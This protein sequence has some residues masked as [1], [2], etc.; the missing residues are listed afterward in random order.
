M[1]SLKTVEL[2]FLLK[3]LG[4]E[5][6]RGKIID[7][8][9]NSATSTAERDRICKDLSAKGLVEYDA[10]VGSFSLAPPG[11]TLLTLDT[12]SLPVT[13]D[14]LKVLKAFKNKGGSMTP[15]K[16]LG[17]PAD[18]RQDLI[19][20]LSDRGMLKITKEAIKEVWLSAQGKQF[21]LYEFEPSGS[22]AA[23]SAT[24][25][26]NY[27][28]FLRENLGRS[29]S[30]SLS[31]P[32]TQSSMPVGLQAKPDA[33]AVLQQIKQLDQLVGSDNYL[34][35]YH[36]REKLQPSMTREELD[37]RLYSLQRDDLIELSS[38][39]DQGDY[40]DRQMAAGIPQNNGGSLFFVT[41]I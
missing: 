39:H 16:L 22:A 3:L 41:V 12:T 2:K 31:Q 11:K 15:G 32:S 35:I 10:Q 18:F 29:G 7:L 17:I 28:R 30:E 36:L 1:S 21:L 27:V 37:E 14:E 6:D 19:R 40:S 33:Q 13:P 34:P 38:L 9:P 23:A 4:C 8:K 5:G 20:S 26:G 25:L 24:M